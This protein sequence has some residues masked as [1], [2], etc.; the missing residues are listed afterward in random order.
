MTE[1]AREVALVAT[2]LDGT[3]LRSDGTLSPYSREVLAE[4]DHRGLPVVLVTARPLRWM[5]DLWEVVGEHGLAI[6]SNGA[7]LYDAH[8]RRIRE[9]T[10]IGR[11]EGLALAARIRDAVP[12][13]RFGLEGASGLALEGTFGEPHHVPEGT[14]VGPLEEVWTEPAAKLMVR[15]PS[16]DP[17]EVRRRVVAAVGEDAT[18]TW[19]VAG[20]VEIS[21]PEVTKA[22]RLAH[23][24]ADL[25]VDRS[26]V[27]AFG[28]MPNDLPMLA[29][30]GQSCAV[31]NAHETVRA[32]ADRVV[33]A[34]DEDGVATTLADLLLG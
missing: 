26:G 4:L 9:L 24:C 29:W 27:L 16:Q 5:G 3:L 17:D 11:D 25:G 33:P 12:G 23:V 6:V 7:I 18:A 31:A 20:L 19:S 10:G 32:A 2:D 8:E 28:D 21:A 30:A 22:W 34:N 14:P 13:A 1:P 15:A